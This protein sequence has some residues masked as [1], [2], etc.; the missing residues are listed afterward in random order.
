MV[1][2]N[3]IAAVAMLAAASV[4]CGAV[5]LTFITVGNAVDGRPIVEG[6]TNLPDGTELMVTLSRKSSSY[7]A[8]DKFKVRGGQFRSAQ[9]SNR[10]SPLMPGV[11]DL[12]IS[13]PI[14]AFQPASV[15]GLL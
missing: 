6:T 10:G 8:Q 9:F 11:Y 12:E 15:R 13:S 7:R 1:W 2:K 14:A 5:P 3:V 4:V